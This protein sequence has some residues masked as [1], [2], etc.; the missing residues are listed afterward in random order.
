MLDL[1]EDAKLG[2]RKLSEDIRNLLK[3]KDPEVSD[4]IPPQTIVDSEEINNEKHPVFVNN[5]Y[6][7]PQPPVLEDRN[8][9]SGLLH[10]IKLSFIITFLGACIIIVYLLI[11]NPEDLIDKLESVSRSFIDFL[12]SIFT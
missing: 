7:Q 8:K 5:N 6:Y 2:L 11:V 10:F 3:R 12:R 4:Q 9:K 1:P